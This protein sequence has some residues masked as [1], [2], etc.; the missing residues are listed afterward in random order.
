MAPPDN[1]C[2]VISV[3][4]GVLT[5]IKVDAIVNAANPCADGYGLRL[6]AFSSISTGSCAFQIPRTRFSMSSNHK[7]KRG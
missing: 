1:S 5:T 6:I 3:F 4:T 7:L 2:P